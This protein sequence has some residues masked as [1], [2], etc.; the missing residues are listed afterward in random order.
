MMASFVRRFR[1]YAVLVLLQTSHRCIVLSDKIM[2][3]TKEPRPRVP[4]RLLKMRSVPNI[5]AADSSIRRN[6]KGI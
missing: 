5:R 1:W 4:A 2:P 6:G 3:E